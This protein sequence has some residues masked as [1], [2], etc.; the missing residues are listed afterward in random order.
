MAPTAELPKP[1][2]P[3]EALILV[4]LTA[5]AAIAFVAVGSLVS[6]FRHWEVDLARQLSVRAYAELHGGRPDPAI[7]DFRSALAFDHDDF[8][9]QFGLAEALEA[10]GRF[11]EAESYL[12]NVRERKPQDGR[13]NLQLARLAAHRQQT[14]QALRYY[15]NAIYGLWDRDPDQNRRQARVELIEFLIERN[16]RT[17]AQAE[18]IAMAAALP[19]DPAL[20][21]KVAALFMAI[22][23]YQNAFAQFR[24]AWRVGR[25]TIAY[26]AGAGEAA[27]QM[28][29]Y[30]TGASYL[31][32]ASDQ[33]ASD[34]LRKMLETS[35]LVLQ[36]DPYPRTLSPAERARRVE[37]GL[38][39]AGA[40]L[41]SCL[42]SERGKA[43][44]IS[45]S[46]SLKD[47]ASEWSKLKNQIRERALFRKAER[48]DMA[49]DF[50]FRVQ[51]ET[52]DEC[53]APSGQDEALLLLGENRE[54]ADE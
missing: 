10:A 4:T 3:R 6:R 26:A 22:Q 49:M 5:I 48:E 46:S 18:M 2:Q 28:G 30:R 34:S 52:K 13:V 17:Q 23:D 44:P 31:E 38:Q 8:S 9:Y 20:H 36:F 7:Q 12:A 21:A 1:R 32:I 41:E 19:Q 15:H 40:R 53:G 45:S 14:E 39:A 29:H 24:Q 27:F 43:A 42:Q 37:R 25:K 51:Q 11:D 50:V 54:G 33:H 35:R 47:L 16:D